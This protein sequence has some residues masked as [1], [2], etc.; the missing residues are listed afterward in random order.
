M[1][2]TE[3]QR[4]TIALSNA[5]P[6]P[7]LTFRHFRGEADYP[8]MLAVL[9]A[10]KLAD[11]IERSDTLAAL[12]HY[13]T[14]LTNCDPY[15]DMLFAEVDGEV[16]A[17]S[18][19]TWW[20]ETEGDRIYM[21]F[22]F[23]LGEWRRKG[24]GSAMLHWNERRLREIAA[25]HPEDGP[26]Y[27][28]SFAMDSEQNTHALLRSKNYKP[29]RFGYDM[30]RDLAA[31]IDPAPMPAGLEVRPSNEAHFRAIW[32]ADQ[33]AFLDHWGHSPGTEKDYERFFSDPLND[34]VLWKVAWD[35]DQVAGMVLNF[36]NPEEN[37]E[38][39]RLRGYT[40]NISVRRPWRRRGLAKSLLTQ[41][42]TMFRDMGYTE[43]A[44]G[45]DAEN[46]TGALRLYKGVGFRVTKESTDYRKPM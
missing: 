32:E 41:S 9:N 13:Y 40:E 12:R 8:H 29:V 6:I 46:R 27:L 22:G 20:K 44:L 26:R 45:V 18:R 30:V 21:L 34:P 37:A 42:L 28:A 31:P 39:E 4:N 14:H 16:I 23:M 43:A 33:E 17:Y 36:V 11:G 10:S 1:I 38:Y 5:P 3:Q 35:G 2:A 7:G 24:I 19:T 15:K 25:G